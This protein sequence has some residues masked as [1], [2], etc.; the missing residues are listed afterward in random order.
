MSFTS[1]LFWTYQRQSD[2]LCLIVHMYD[3]VEKKHLNINMHRLG[4][5]KKLP[6]EWNG[7][8]SAYDQCGST[9]LNFKKEKKNTLNGSQHQGC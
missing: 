4:Y 5:L 6:Q 2:R 1:D 9:S 7:S 3:E 8:G